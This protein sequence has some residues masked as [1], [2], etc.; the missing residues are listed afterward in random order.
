MT[1]TVDEV[2]YR[3]YHREAGGA[4]V[5]V[6]TPTGDS[7][8]VLRHVVRHS[9]NGFGWG[10]GGSGPAD[11]ARSLLLAALDGAARCLSCGGSQQ[12]VYDVDQDRDRPYVPGVDSG[13]DPELVARCLVCD[14]GWRRVPYQA[15]KW[16]HVCKWTHEW[17]ITRGEVLAWLHA[18]GIEP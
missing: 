6:E 18:N 10:Y 2:V 8:G 1:K 7:L 5:L 11:L 15:F 14:D 12:V 3:G 9:P 16:A 17:K 4:M 13:V